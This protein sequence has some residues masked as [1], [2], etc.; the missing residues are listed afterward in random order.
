MR[1][2]KPQETSV[3]FISEEFNIHQNSERGRGLL[4]RRSAESSLLQF[5]I[6]LPT[7]LVSKYFEFAL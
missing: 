4:A 7:N 5:A 2:I 1:L 3:E 6:H